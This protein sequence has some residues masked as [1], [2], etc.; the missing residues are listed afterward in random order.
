MRNHF[1]GQMPRGIN[2]LVSLVHLYLAHNRFSGEIDG[3]LFGGMKALVKVH[4]EGNQFSGQIPESLTKLPKLT[5]LNL[6]DNMF[7]GKIPAFKQKNLVTVNVA[8]N[9]LEGRIPF[10][11]GLMNFT[12]FSGIIVISVYFSFINYHDHLSHS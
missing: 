3:N 7:T 4:L 11:L 5:E 9:Q 8:N 1:E 10:T 2:G 12:F 6:E